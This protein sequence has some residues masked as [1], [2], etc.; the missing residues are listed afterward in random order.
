MAKINLG[1]G[2]GGSGAGGGRTPPRRDRLRTGTSLKSQL[3]G[4]EFKGTCQG[5]TCTGFSGLFSCFMEMGFL[6]IL[7]FSESHNIAQP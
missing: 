5:Q 6:V 1:D 3:H 4:A 7:S 2:R